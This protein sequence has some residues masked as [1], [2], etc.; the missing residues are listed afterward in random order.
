MF[1]GICLLIFLAGGCINKPQRYIEEIRTPGEATMTIIEHD[2]SGNN[3]T[4]DSDNVPGN[5]TGGTSG[6]F[7]EDRIGNVPYYFFAVYNEP[8]NY[9]GGEKNIEESFQYLIKMVENADGYNIKLTLMF[10]AQWAAYI[11]ENPGRQAILDQWKEN[12]H[13]IA[14]FHRGIY[15]EN[16]DGYTDYPP[17]EARQIRLEMGKKNEKYMG[18]LADFTV[19]LKKINQWINSG[20]FNEEVNGDIIPDEIIYATGRGFSYCRRCPGFFRDI[21]PEV[22]INEFTSTGIING[23]ERKWLSHFQITSEDF[24][25][26]AIETSEK[27]N[28][29]AAYGVAFQ[30]LEEQTA[31]YHAYLDYLYS[32]DPE[33]LNSKTLTQVIEKKLLPEKSMLK[34]A[35]NRQYQ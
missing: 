2:I 12:N 6:S 11:A 22:G 10:P 20:F 8:S 25:S 5:D 27:L 16:W 3:S 21:D 15:D 26:A 33:G 4:D 30:S 18:T 28:S 7:I 9:P 31:L 14:C 34:E 19:E 29:S 17:A 1:I 35:I 13:E 32:I 24:L 23:I